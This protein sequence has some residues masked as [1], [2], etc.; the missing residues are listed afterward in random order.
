MRGVLRRI[1]C[2]CVS[3][4]EITCFDRKQSNVI[5][6]ITESQGMLISSISDVDSFN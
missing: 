6:L 4:H 1:I 3:S 5:L 2:I